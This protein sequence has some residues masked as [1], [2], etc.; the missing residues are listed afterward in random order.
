M[1]YSVCFFSLSL[2]FFFFFFFFA[3][4]KVLKNWASF[5][6][7]TSR[8]V[9]LSHFRVV[10]LSCAG[11]SAPPLVIQT[12]PN[13]MA[14]Y[15]SAEPKF[16]AFKHLCSFFVAY[17]LQKL[18]PDIDALLYVDTDMLFL[19]PV[20]EMWRFFREFNSTQIAGLAAEHEPEQAGAD[21]YNRFSKIPYHGQLGWLHS[22]RFLLKNL[23][24]I[25]TPSPPIKNKR[26]KYRTK[27]DDISMVILVS[28]LQGGL[29]SI[30]PLPK[31]TLIL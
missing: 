8:A 10:L 24:R 28:C 29:S 21:W 19:R 12:Q 30:L 25:P 16:N 13:R 14:Q 1:S 3:P 6:G 17:F 5:L 7:R 31:K 18:L 20:D 9:L 23:A 2:F 26:Q 27:N 22:I 11:D 15:Y 4:L